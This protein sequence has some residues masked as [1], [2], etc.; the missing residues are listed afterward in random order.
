MKILEN[1]NSKKTSRKSFIFYT[2]IALMAGYA[3]I[4]IPFKLFGRKE[5]IRSENST[6]SEFMFRPN[7]ESIK[8]S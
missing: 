1:L 3:L 7:T 8:R 5:E 2:G 4:K 6:G